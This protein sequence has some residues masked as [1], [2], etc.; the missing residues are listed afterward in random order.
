MASLSYSLYR[1]NNS[2]ELFTRASS[3][4]QSYGPV[5][6]VFNVENE[7][8]TAADVDCTGNPLSSCV[9]F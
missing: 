2:I 7:R 8:S 9:D 3:F 4:F 1:V 6:A 5:I